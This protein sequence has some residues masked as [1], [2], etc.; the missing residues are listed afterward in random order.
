[1][2]LN[3]KIA[4]IDLT[5]GTIE[6]KPIPL[7]MRK[8]YL[9]GRGLDA[10]LLYNNTEAGVDAGWGERTQVIAMRLPGSSPRVS[11][12]VIRSASACSGCHMALSML[13]TGTC[14]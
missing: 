14:E 8:K 13:I 9:G 2:A 6:T 10:Y 12:S 1:M 7:E 11:C 3:R 4:Y 5:S